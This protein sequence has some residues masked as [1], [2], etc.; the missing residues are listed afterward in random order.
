MP[1]H[2]VHALS[3]VS[4]SLVCVHGSTVFAKHHHLGL[5]KLMNMPVVAA[6]CQSFVRG[7]AQTPDSD[8]HS[9]FQPQVKSTPAASAAEQIQQD[10]KDH[11]V[12]VYMK[13]LEDC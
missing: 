6:A 8:M 2:H 12:F 3:N 13:V 10:I 9:D 4:E 7:M 11:K 1:S 5:S